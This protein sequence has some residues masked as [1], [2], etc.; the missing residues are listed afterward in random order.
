MSS[1]PPIHRRT[2]RFL[3]LQPAHCI[4][5]RL[6]WE[7]DSDDQRARLRAARRE[8]ATVRGGQNKRRH[9]R[10]RGE[11]GEGDKEEVNPDLT[12]DGIRWEPAGNLAERSTVQIE[13]EFHSSKPK[14][15]NRAMGFCGEDDRLFF[16]APQDGDVRRR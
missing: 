4:H 15:R 16:P 14:P 13:R 5:E 11:A 9:A 8:R 7:A 12:F 1:L 2:T 6:H 3:L 10:P